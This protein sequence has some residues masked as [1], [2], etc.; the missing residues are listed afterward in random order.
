VARRK[1]LEA[2]EKL[3]IEK[4]ASDGEIER[5][6]VRIRTE[7]P[8]TLDDDHQKG[9]TLKRK[10]KRGDKGNQW[11]IALEGESER[12]AEEKARVE[13]SRFLSILMTL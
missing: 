1:E 10:G 12:K 2:L 11:R 13:V 9:N 5:A 6:K 8:Q 7:E 3:A 4:G